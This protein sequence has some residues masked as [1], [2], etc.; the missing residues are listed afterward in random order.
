MKKQA[1]NV[2]AF[3]KNIQK[4]TGAK[5][6]LLDRLLKRLPKKYHDRVDGIEIEDNLIPGCKYMLYWNEKYQDQL[7]EAGGC[8]PVVNLEEAREFIKDLVSVC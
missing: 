3:G 1:Y 5:L 8:I 2:G 7:G 4:K 6:M